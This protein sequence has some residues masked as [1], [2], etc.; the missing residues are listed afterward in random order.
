MKEADLDDKISGDKNQN[1][2]NINTNNLT[3]ELII[4]N[5]DEKNND[6]GNHYIIANEQIGFKNDIYESANIF[7]KLFFY[8]GFKILKITSKFKIEASNLG[9]LDEINDSKN[10]FNEIYYYWEEKK[11]KKINNHGLI[12]AFLRSNVKSIILIFILSLYEAAAEYFQ[13]LLI[14]GFIDYFDSGIIFL[15]LPNI[16]YVGAIFIII[17]FVTIFVNLQ[18]TLIEQKIGLRIRYQLNSLV[19]QKILKISPSS[20]SQRTSKGKIVNFIQNDSYK[21][22][23]LIKYSPGIIIYPGKIVAY[24]YLLFE[25][26]GISFL[27][28]LIA[29][30]VMILIIGNG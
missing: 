26:F 18:N 19:F 2:N 14:K 7:S 15:G 17:Q 22:S 24:I 23:T 3:E 5:E 8:W 28:G 30:V 1:S 12:R 13:V 21:I 11:Y 16:K 10:Y 4:Q 27:F 9:R 29:F 6:K 25:F 20:F